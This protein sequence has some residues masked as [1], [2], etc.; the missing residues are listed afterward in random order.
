MTKK[1]DGTLDPGTVD[2]DSLL[3]VKES[4]PRVG[5]YLHTMFLAILEKLVLLGCLQTRSSGAGEGG[6]LREEAYI[7]ENLFLWGYQSIHP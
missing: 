7:K 2:P 6:S 1:W 5:V 3:T 4:L